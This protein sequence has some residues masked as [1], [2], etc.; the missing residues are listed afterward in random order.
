MWFF[1][2]ISRVLKIST[3]RKEKDFENV[4]LSLLPHQTT[5]SQNTQ[6]F[7]QRKVSFLRLLLSPMWF[8]KRHLIWNSAQAM[9]Y[10]GIVQGDH[11]DFINHR[12]S[13]WTQLPFFVFVFLSSYIS[14]RLCIKHSPLLHLPS[15]SQ[16]QISKTHNVS[17]HH[18]CP[19]YPFLSF[20]L[21]RILT[22]V[23]IRKLKKK[24]T[25]GKNVLL[26][27]QVEIVVYRWWGGIN[28][29]P[30]SKN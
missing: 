12:F 3:R 4:Q 26:R 24:V 1:F 29:Y 21:L 14:L 15:S 25:G 23:Y 28:T 10:T 2:L 27:R 6:M 9:E 20:P 18:P 11:G 5:G 8:Q 16:P 22:D 30:F 13:D 7:M 19:L 17:N